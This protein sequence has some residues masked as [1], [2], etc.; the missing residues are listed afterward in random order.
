MTRNGQVTT[1]QTEQCRH[2]PNPLS[3]E[4]MSPD[5]RLQAVASLLATGFLRAWLR[6]AEKKTREGLDVPADLSDPS[7]R[8]QVA[9][10]RGL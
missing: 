1:M 3:P 2:R 10:E 6:K 4:H 7:P 8:T 5:E 9:G